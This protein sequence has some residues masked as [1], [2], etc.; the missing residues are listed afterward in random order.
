M[1]M[2]KL[3]GVRRTTNQVSVIVSWPED[4]PHWEDL[5]VNTRNNI[6]NDIRITV[7]SEKKNKPLKKKKPI[8][9]YKKKKKIK[10]KIN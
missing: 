10:K 5:P 1:S 8:K 9:K 3:N 6:R 4:G 2:S 7:W